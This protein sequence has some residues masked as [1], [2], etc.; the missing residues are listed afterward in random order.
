MFKVTDLIVLEPYPGPDVNVAQIV[1]Y[2]ESRDTD[3]G[4]VPVPKRYAEQGWSSRSYVMSFARAAI[5]VAKEFHI[6]VSGFVGQI[7]HETN[8]L[9]FGK[10]VH[11]D[12][13]NFGGIGATGGGE[14]GH[15][16][17][18]LL[19]GLIVS[20]EHLMVYA[21]GED[22]YQ[23]PE[24]YNY[25]PRYNAVVR[26]GWDGTSPTWAG[27]AGKWAEHIGTYRQGI[28][29]HANGVIAMYSRP[30]SEGESPLLRVAISAGHHN[31]QGGN[32]TEQ[33]IV[34]EITERMF[35]HLNRTPGISCRS[36]TPDG[37]DDDELPG[38]GYT[39]E[40]IYAQWSQTLARWAQQGWV[41]DLCIEEHTQG[42]R[43][44]EVGGFFGI[45]PS[46]SGDVDVDV[47]DRL[48]P[49]VCDYIERETP[50]PIWAD[51]VMAE[52]ETSVGADG[53]R[54]GYFSATAYLAADT[55]RVLFEN[56]AH[57]NPDDLALLRRPEV[58]NQL[59]QAKVAAIC[60]YYDIEY[61]WETAPPVEPPQTSIHFP[62]TDKSIVHPYF[63][64]RWQELSVQQFNYK[65]VGLPIT[66]TFEVTFPDGSKRLVQCFE[67]DVWS[68]NDTIEGDWS[69]QSANLSERAYIL[70]YAG[71]VGI[72]FWGS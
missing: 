21:L 23:W 45:H 44:T 29:R 68:H 14:P 70:S 31:A 2:I 67:K 26:A 36:L 40:R 54:L 71:M 69:V 17:P 19:Y 15:S 53:D 55:E 58:I 5:V 20:A 32:P 47:R 22:F 57:T 39:Q 28:E 34:A 50:L 59:C 3:L 37:P 8:V 72:D 1:R 63:V 61:V 35:Y 52:H 4:P 65:H 30:L 6:P 11:P 18:H 13:L 64:K 25:D 12:Q 27:L 10:D 24:Y 43:N 38:D 56:G 16:F 33:E 60:E 49:L 42:V 48:I 41:P 62:E 51:G 7:F 46:M 66:G 9:R